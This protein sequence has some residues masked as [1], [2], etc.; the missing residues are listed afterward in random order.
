MTDK[1]WGT[2]IHAISEE[3]ILFIT[4]LLQRSYSTIFEPRLFGS[5]T[6]AAW[7]DVFAVT[8]P[9]FSNGN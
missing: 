2:K 1:F 3:V 6:A 8:T 9:N 7:R 4:S 5:H